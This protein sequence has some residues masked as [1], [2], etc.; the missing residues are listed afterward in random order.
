MIVLKIIKKA[1]GFFT[2]C[3]FMFARSREY[4]CSEQVGKVVAFD[5]E[6]RFTDL[7]HNFL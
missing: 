5:F 4:P 2:R 3:F 1:L 7:Q 6:E